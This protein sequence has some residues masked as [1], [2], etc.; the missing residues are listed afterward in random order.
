LKILY[1]GYERLDM[2]HQLF[3]E[4]SW[5]PP[6]FPSLEDI[7]ENYLFK[8]QTAEVAPGQPYAAEVDSWQ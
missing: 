8:N 6:G 2:R 1:L 5:R 7:P 3:L 4:T